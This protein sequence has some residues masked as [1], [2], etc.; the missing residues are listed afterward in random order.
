MEGAKYTRDIR[1]KVKSVNMEMDLCCDGATKKNKT[2]I[3]LLRKYFA[4]GAVKNIGVRQRGKLEDILGRKKST[5]T[6]EGWRRTHILIKELRAIC[7]S[8]GHGAGREGRRGRLGWTRRPRRAHARCA[9][10]C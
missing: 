10:L 7:M 3:A 5:H 1:T 9:D 4:R 2:C 6:R 8:R